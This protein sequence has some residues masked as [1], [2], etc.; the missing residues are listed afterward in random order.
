MF[1]VT[2]QTK[3]KHY[4][5]S[6]RSRTFLCGLDQNDYSEFALD[7]LLDELVDDGDEVVCFRVVDKDSKIT[8]DNSIEQGRYKTEAYRLLDHI[9]GRNKDGEKSL[10]LVLEFA[11]GKVQET[12]QRMVSSLEFS[13]PV[14]V[15]VARYRETANGSQIELYEPACLIVGT[16]GRSLGGIQGLLPGSVSKYCLQNSAVP[17][18]VVRPSS[19][20]EKKK[21][22]RRED[23]TRKSYMD[24]FEQSGAQGSQ[25]LEKVEDLN[26]SGNITDEARKKEAIAVAKAI[27]MPAHNAI[28]FRNVS[29]G[30]STE[31]EPLTKVTSTK[32][33]NTIE[34]ENPTPAARIE[35]DDPLQNYRGSA[36]QGNLIGPGETD[37][38]DQDT[39][40]ERKRASTKEA[41]QRLWNASGLPPKATGR[42]AGL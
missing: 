36:V 41:T 32:S 34:P 29:Y 21:R 4:A 28:D 25:I 37:A 2:L 39:E 26:L 3:H 20:R 6:K 5:Y 11:V 33:G 1:S 8:S 14:I 17:V 19:K 13:Y 40:Q 15:G 23:P 35:P 30:S 12:I 27:G 24:I 7:W 31:G 9:K 38:E 18:I 42:E 22:K 16:R 10:S